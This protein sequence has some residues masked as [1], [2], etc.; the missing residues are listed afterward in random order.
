MSR[1]RKIAIA[2]VAVM[3]MSLAATWGW[4]WFIRGRFLVNVDVERDAKPSRDTTLTVAHW[5][6]RG[7]SPDI[8]A[9]RAPKAPA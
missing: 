1:A 5:S 4:Q 2:I 8:D 3:V 6:C 7:S 9:G